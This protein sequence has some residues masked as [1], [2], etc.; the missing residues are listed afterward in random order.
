MVQLEQRVEYESRRAGTGQREPAMERGPGQHQLRH[1][2]G[3]SMLKL[4]PPQLRSLEQ[5]LTNPQRALANQA[6]RA[7]KALLVE[8]DRER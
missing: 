1:V 8:R 6:V 4:A 5:A 3:R 2:L 7:A